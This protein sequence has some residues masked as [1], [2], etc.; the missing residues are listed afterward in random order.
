MEIV[1][2]G[3]DESEGPPVQPLDDWYCW[4]LEAYVTLIQLTINIK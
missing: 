4:S 1:K 2:S 3:S